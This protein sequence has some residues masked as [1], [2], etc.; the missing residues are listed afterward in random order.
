MEQRVMMPFRITESG[1]LRASRSTKYVT[2][3]PLCFVNRTAFLATVERTWK[4]MQSS[5]LRYV[6]WSAPSGPRTHPGPLLCPSDPAF[7]A[8]L[9]LFHPDITSE[10]V[11][12]KVTKT[13]PRWLHT[14]GLLLANKRK[15]SFE[16]SG[17]GT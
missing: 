1:E 6:T 5:C 7:L 16:M 8:V 14:Q 11:R 15:S 3:D 9:F 13:P 2:H 17:A 4:E 10:Y 12:G